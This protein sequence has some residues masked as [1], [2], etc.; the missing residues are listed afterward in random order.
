MGRGGRVGCGYHHSAPARGRLVLGAVALGVV[1]LGISNTSC[2]PYYC[3]LLHVTVYRTA[4]ELGKPLWFFSR[5][6]TVASVQQ[7][8]PRQ[9]LCPTPEAPR[10]PAESTNYSP[11]PLPGQL[12]RWGRRH[13]SLAPAPLPKHRRPVC[14]SGPVTGAETPGPHAP[15][16]REREPPRAHAPTCEHLAGPW[17]TLNTSGRPVHCRLRPASRGPAC[18]SAVPKWPPRLPGEGPP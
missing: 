7:R 12:T 13:K 8:G 1:V 18:V 4:R 5:S 6:C 11:R 9:G 10:S 17:G 2:R 16:A 14:K 15:T 3:F